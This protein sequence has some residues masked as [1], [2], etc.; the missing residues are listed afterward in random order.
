MAQD[1][2][3]DQSKDAECVDC[4]REMLASAMDGHLFCPGCGKQS[5]APAGEDG[6]NDK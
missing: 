1:T 6:T 3:N 5:P 2:G 4:R